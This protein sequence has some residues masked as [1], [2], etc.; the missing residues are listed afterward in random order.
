MCSLSLNNPLKLGYLTH[1][2]RIYFESQGQ[3][4][5]PDKWS[6]SCCQGQLQ[7]ASTVGSRMNANVAQIK[8][9]FRSKEYLLSSLVLNGLITLYKPKQVPW[10]PEINTWW[11][12]LNDLT[13]VAMQ[14]QNPSIS[15]KPQTN[16][17]CYLIN[18]LYFW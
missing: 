15:N 6:C 2:G 5:V 10:L 3:W 14:S 17:T 13:G 18:E 16:N 12:W 9:C 4:L 1:W 11:S 7:L 8:S